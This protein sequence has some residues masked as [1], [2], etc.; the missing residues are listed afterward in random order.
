MP[1]IP[2]LVDDA[3]WHLLSAK[4]DMH[5]S[6]ATSRGVKMCRLPLQ[7]IPIKTKNDVNGGKTD[8]IKRFTAWLVK[9]LRLFCLTM[10][11]CS[12]IVLNIAYK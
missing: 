12:I 2:C 10:S 6:I 3:E 7:P 1:G 11:C 4:P 8:Q 5:Q 9:I